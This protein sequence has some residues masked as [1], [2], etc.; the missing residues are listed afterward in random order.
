MLNRNFKTIML[1]WFMSSQ[2]TANNAPRFQSQTIYNIGNSGEGAEFPPTDAGTSDRE[3]IS[4]CIINGL[5]QLTTTNTIA[6]Q[7]ANR[8]FIAVGTGTTEATE[9]DYTLESENT[10]ITCEAITQ[11]YTTSYKRQITATFNNPTNQDITLKEV[12]LFFEIYYN[13]YNYANTIMLARE[14]INVT[15]PAG[16]SKAITMEI[17]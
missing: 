3:E 4:K 13:N 8:L 10:N 17:G 7:S 15:I 14:N 1:G 11:T 5:N 12:G 6:R 16:E 9:E 2:V